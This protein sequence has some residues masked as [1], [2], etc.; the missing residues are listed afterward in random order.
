MADVHGGEHKQAICAS[1]PFIELAHE[2]SVGFRQLG[3]SRER[4]ILRNAEI[5][6]LEVAIGVQ[7]TY[8]SIV[9]ILIVP[10]VANEEPVLGCGQRKQIHV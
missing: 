4:F 3:L 10:C 1:N 2:I 8:N 7:Q 5:D 9:F 6:P